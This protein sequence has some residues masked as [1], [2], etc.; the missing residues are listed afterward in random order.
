MIRIFIILNTIKYYGYPDIYDGSREIYGI[1]VIILTAPNQRENSSAIID[2]GQGST[3]ESSQLS[4]R[5]PVSN[6][7]DTLVPL[8]TTTALR[9]TQPVRSE[10][11]QIAGNI[12]RSGV[13]IASYLV[14]NSIWKSIFVR[15]TH[16]C[17][18]TAPT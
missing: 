2:K 1:I 5:S 12:Y 14:T 7:I 10:I 6:T 13:G 9:Q 3:Q 4:H 8:F 16:L 11:I 18:L 17:D 15:G